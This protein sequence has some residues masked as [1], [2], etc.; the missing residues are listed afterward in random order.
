MSRKSTIVDGSQNGVCVVTQGV[1]A[2][3]FLQEAHINMIALAER[4]ALDGRNVTL[5]WVGGNQEDIGELQKWMAYYRDTYGIRVDWFEHPDQMIWKDSTSAYF[6]FGV[7][8]YLKRNQF[9]EVYVPLEEG[10]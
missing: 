6:S 4:F 3:R 10:L 7:Y 9:S 5:L 8:S 1:D 2:G